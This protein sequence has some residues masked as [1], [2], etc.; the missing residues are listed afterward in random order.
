ME[1]TDE[2]LAIEVQ[3]GKT[4]A[5]GLLV[6][7]YQDKLL[8]YARKFLSNKEDIEDQVQEV[9]IKAYTNMQSF[10][11]TLRFSPWIYRI[12]HNTFINA[13]KRNQFLP[14]SFF[15]PDTFFP[16]L[17]ASEETDKEALLREM[18]SMLE[19]SL[20]TLPIK[21]REPL[22]LY[23]YEHMSYQDIADILHIPITTVGVRI[24]RAK[25]KLK[26]NVAHHI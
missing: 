9:F 3:N 5:F 10:D 13:L 21:Y 8:R 25:E 18:H 12:A 24:T 26:R 2:M 23:F 11:V 6:E 22:I 1:P 4:E 14:V 16:Q 19:T 15:D 20:D 17:V 7:R